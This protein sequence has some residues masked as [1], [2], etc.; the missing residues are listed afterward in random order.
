MQL[1]I[2]LLCFSTIMASIVKHMDLQNVA[3]TLMDHQKEQELGIHV[4]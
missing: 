2:V 4:V 1:W 3:R